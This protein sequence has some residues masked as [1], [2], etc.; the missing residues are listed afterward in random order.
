MYTLGDPKSFPNQ[1]LQQYEQIGL[2]YGT[3]VF[4]VQGFPK[5]I[6]FFSR[7][8]KIPVLLYYDYEIA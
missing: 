6:S 7:L 2:D 1:L 5:H 4:D 8:K 3:P